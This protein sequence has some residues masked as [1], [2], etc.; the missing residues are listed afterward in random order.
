MEIIGIGKGG[1][2]EFREEPADRGFSGAGDT[3]DDD[4]AWW[5]G[6]RHICMRE[7]DW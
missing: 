7:S 6:G 4:D 3:H 2:E 1:P 5:S